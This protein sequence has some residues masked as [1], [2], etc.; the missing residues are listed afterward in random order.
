MKVTPIGWDFAKRCSNFMADKQ[1]KG[2]I[3]GSDPFFSVFSCIAAAMPALSDVE[4]RDAAR[5]FLDESEAQLG[6]AAHRD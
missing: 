5:L 6:L 4:T 3:K 1:I 2:S